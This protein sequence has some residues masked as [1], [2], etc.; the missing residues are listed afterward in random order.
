MVALSEKCEVPVSFASLILRTKS[1]AA[2]VAVRTR[3]ERIA[4]RRFI[5]IPALFFLFV[6]RSGLFFACRLG[7]PR[8]LG[9]ADV[10]RLR[11]SAHLAEDNDDL[12]ARLKLGELLFVPFPENR[13]GIDLKDTGAD[14]SLHRDGLF[15]HGNNGAGVI[16]RPWRELSRSGQDKGE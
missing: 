15:V 14:L 2:A 4:G 5:R 12:R 11:N 3:A 13:P 9:C 8:R 1:S 7:R 16:G 10:L 6:R